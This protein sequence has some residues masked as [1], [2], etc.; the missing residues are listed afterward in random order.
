MHWRCSVIESLKLSNHGMLLSLIRNW[1]NSPR[2][3]WIS[4]HIQ[5]R[6]HQKQPSAALVFSQDQRSRKTVE[7]RYRARHHV[8]WFG[9]YLFKKKCVYC[10]THIYIY[11]HIYS[12][13]F[14]AKD[15]RVMF[16]MSPHL[17]FVFW[18]KNPPTGYQAHLPGTTRGARHDGSGSLGLDP[19]HHQFSKDTA[20]GQATNEIQIPSSLVYRVYRN[21]GSNFVRQRRSQR[22]KPFM[23]CSQHQKRTEKRKAKSERQPLQETTTKC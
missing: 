21:F 8:F 12:H 3:S 14:V 10:S 20:V 7:C 6:S 1:I 11:I 18:W 2:K 17:S 4:W 5:K 15:V 16:L 9:L 23:T 13:M 19:K 22:P